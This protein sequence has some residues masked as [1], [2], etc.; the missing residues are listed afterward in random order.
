MKDQ[1]PAVGIDQFQSTGSLYDLVIHLNRYEPGPRRTGVARTGV[2]LL[3]PP[4][5][6]LKLTVSEVLLFTKVSLSLPALAPNRN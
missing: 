6:V 4:K 1:T 5:P 2:V 3:V